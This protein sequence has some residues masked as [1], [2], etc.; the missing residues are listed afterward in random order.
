MSQVYFVALLTLAFLAAAWL[1]SNWLLRRREQ[2]MAGMDLLESDD[3][4][5]MHG[6]S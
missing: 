5:R 1:A 4:E 3:H 2:R 6:P